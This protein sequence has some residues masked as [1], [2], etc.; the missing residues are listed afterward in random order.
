MKRIRDLLREPEIE[1]DRA[2]YDKVHAR[3][4]GPVSHLFNKEL[5]KVYLTRVNLNAALCDYYHTIKQIR[6]LKKYID[7]IGG[8]ADETTR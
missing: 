8:M 5:V 3:V 7:W 6:A 4:R 2:M 1:L